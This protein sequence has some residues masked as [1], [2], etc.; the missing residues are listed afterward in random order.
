MGG[1]IVASI[2]NLET[3]ICIRIESKYSSGGGKCGTW[4]KLWWCKELVSGCYYVVM[5]EGFDGLPAT[6]RR[7]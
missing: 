6:W 1:E 2:G 3:D 7:I 4:K 5:E